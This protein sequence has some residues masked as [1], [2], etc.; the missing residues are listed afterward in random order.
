[1]RL[2]ADDADVVD[3]RA[4]FGAEFADVDAGFTV[5]RELERAGEE[6][7]GLA[8]GAEIDG[9]GAL[10]GEL[11]EGWFGVEHIDVGGAA[12]EEEED[13]V[14]GFAGHLGTR[15]VAGE[16]IEADGAEAS[17]HLREEFA[18]RHFWNITSLVESRTWARLG[19]SLWAR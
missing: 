12:G 14:F 5:L 1:M 8:F 4:D 3:D 10:A 13:D 2:R 16:G 6:A 17:A 9:A 15:V 18:S 11:G 19:R 7:T